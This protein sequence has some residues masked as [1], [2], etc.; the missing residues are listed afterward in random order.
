M[1]IISNS[2]MVRLEFSITIMTILINQTGKNGEI[3]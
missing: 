2:K 3:G 1:K